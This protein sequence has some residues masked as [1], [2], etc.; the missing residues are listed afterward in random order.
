M[1]WKTVHM[2]KSQPRKK[3]QS[4]NSDLPLDFFSIALKVHLTLKP[5]FAKIIRLILWSNLAQKFF[6]LV[7]S[8]SQST[9]KSR[10]F[11]F[12]TEFT[13]HGS[14]ARCDVKSRT[15]ASAVPVII[16]V[17][18]SILQS[19]EAIFRV[20]GFRWDSAV[21]KFLFLVT[22]SSTSS[23]SEMTFDSKDSEIYYIAEDTRRE[24]ALKRWRPSWYIG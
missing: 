15:Y 16:A 8:S 12:T 9:S 23:D 21:D 1:P 17:R 22:M 13:G 7:K 20:Q 14:R 3:N 6:D 4:E 24:V 18:S 11:W 10:H 5:F 2:A 19:V